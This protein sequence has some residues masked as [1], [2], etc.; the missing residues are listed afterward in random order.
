VSVSVGNYLTTQSAQA[1]SAAGGSSNFQ[2][3]GLSDN[4]IGSFTNTNG[5]VAIAGINGSFYAASNTTQGTSGTQNLSAVTLAGAGIASIGITNGSLLVSAAYPALSW[6]QNGINDASAPAVAQAQSL[7]SIRKLYIPNPLAVSLVRVIASVSGAT[8]TN[9]SSAYFDYS[10]SI[11]LYTRNGSTLSSLA[12]G[13]ATNNVSWSSNATNSMN[14][15]VYLPVAINAVT[16]APGEYWMAHHLSTTNSA[17]SGAA[18]T[19]LGVSVSMYANVVVGGSA[20][21]QIR[22]F[23]AGT[24]ATYDIAV[25]NG[26]IST[27]ATLASVPFTSISNNGTRA[28]AANLFVELAN[29]SI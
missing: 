4:N 9:N 18:T 13:S 28:V 14:G 5:S 24:N 16:L 17:V 10:Q 15:A 23:G 6:Y 26:L 12:S 11:V 22:P 7:V 3:L 19:A 20:A 29:Y 25:G 1:F 27:G 21:H 8:T 2:T